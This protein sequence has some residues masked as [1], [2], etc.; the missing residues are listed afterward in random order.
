MAPLPPQ[1]PPGV[2]FAELR[3]LALALPAVEEGVCYGTPAFRVKGRFLL[4]LREDGET[5]AVRIPM[6]E[7]DAL[8]QMDPD[9]YFLTDHYRAY[10]AILVRLARVRRGQLADLLELAWRAQAPKRLVAAFD[11]LQA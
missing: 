4:R 5:L 11:A 8:L 6:D 2:D 1:D 9:V 10:P 7:R 3:E